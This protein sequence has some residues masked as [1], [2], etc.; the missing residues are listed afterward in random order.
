MV[1]FLEIGSKEIPTLSGMKYTDT[2]LEESYRCVLF[3]NK[4]FTIYLG[5]D[6]VNLVYILI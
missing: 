2:N 5:C 3:Q 4:Q 1:K 6:Q